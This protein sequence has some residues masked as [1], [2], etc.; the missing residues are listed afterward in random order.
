MLTVELPA[1]LS[2]VERAAIAGDIQMLV[3]ASQGAQIR[4]VEML[5]RDVRNLNRLLLRFGSWLSE[6]DMVLEK[7]GLTGP[8]K[9]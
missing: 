4:E 5:R 2:E 8:S 3:S 1:S 9:T 6:I 7:A